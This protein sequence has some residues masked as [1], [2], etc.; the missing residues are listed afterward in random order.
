MTN[1][2][3]FC[4]VNSGILKEIERKKE[5]LKS[6]SNYTIGN[7]RRKQKALQ[8]ESSKHSVS[9]EL[10]GYNTTTSADRREK[11][12]ERKRCEGNLIKALDW[13]LENYHVELSAGFIKELGGM[14]EPYNFKAFRDRNVTIL[15][16]KVSPPAPNKVNREIFR[17][18][19]MNNSLEGSI[20]KALHSHFHLAR[21]HPFLDG[22]GR[23]ARLVQNIILEKGKYFPI[24]IR[25]NDRK[26]YIGLINEAVYSRW[27]TEGN[28]N[29]YESR[30]Y[31]ESK[32]RLIMNSLTFKERDY[33]SGIVLNTSKKLMTPE[34]SEFYNFLA[35]KIRDVLQ[36]EIEKIYEKTHSR[37][38]RRNV[39]RNK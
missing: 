39:L 1:Q 30:K 17:F 31:I 16:A 13:G 37:K 19:L 26:E 5:I 21:I 4:L 22:N 14:V 34:Q 2:N 35:L 8:R 11:S 23:V 20:E 38:K 32:E 10:E 9:L 29:S 33:H 12:K 28:L 18:I 7:C 15:G 36:E 25:K 6:N 24:V 3:K 27:V